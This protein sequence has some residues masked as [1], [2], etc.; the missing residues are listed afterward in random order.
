MNKTLRLFTYWQFGINNDAFNYLMSKLDIEFC[1]YLYEDIE[2]LRKDNIRFF[3]IYLYEGLSYYKNGRIKYEL[4]DEILKAARPYESTAMDII[5]RWRRSYITKESYMSIKE[6]Y[7]ILMRFWNNFIKEHKI[8]FVIITIIPHIPSEYLV[9]VLCQIYKI[10]VIILN[11]FLGIKGEKINYILKPSIEHLDLNFDIRYLTLKKT[12]NKNKVHIELASELERYFEQYQIN[13]VKTD[14]IIVFLN[15]KN[16]LKELILKYL[17][18][19]KIYLKRSDIKILLNKII[20]LAKIRIETYFFLHKVSGL[21]HE[22]DLCKKYYLFALHLQPEA[23]TLPGSGTAFTNQ[24]LAIRLISNNLP[25]DT[26]L[27]VKEH[28]SYWLQ[29]E[30]LESVYES[31]NIEFYKEINSLRN[32]R[33]IKHTYLSQDL[34]KNC[35]GVVTITG[36]IGFE[37][38]FAGKPVLVFGY[39]FYQ[40]YPSVFFIK[41]NNDCKRALEIIAKTKF[42]FNEESI[43]V[44]LK[45]LEKYVIPIGVREKRGTDNGMPGVSDQ[46]RKNL[47]N[48]IIEFYDEFYLNSKNE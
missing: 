47:V 1:A 29:K 31:R 20:Y 3:P 18:R 37:A 39:A 36:S 10:P 16:N 4:D 6:L 33:L 48:K 24:L 41:T 9:Y 30:R 46:D 32:V 13:N 11:N 12:Y 8:N 43:R 42:S 23:T 7:V 38:I 40:S 28:P 21:E 35:L 44:F 34:M 2:D 15:E 25:N 22:A 45:A 26:F 19:I 27:Y 17:E 14:K 5:N